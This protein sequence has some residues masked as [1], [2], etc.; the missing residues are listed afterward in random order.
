MS[1]PR[2]YPAGTEAVTIP[3]AARMLGVSPYSLHNRVRDGTVPVFRLGRLVRI[4]R[5]TL[6]KIL[7]GEQLSK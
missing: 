3:E 6:E 5:K 7:N 4:S 2:E 1:K